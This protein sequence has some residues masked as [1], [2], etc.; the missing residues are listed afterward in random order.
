MRQRAGEGGS[1]SA[2]P[3]AEREAYFAH[4]YTTYK[5]TVRAGARSK[6]LADA[7]TEDVAQEVFAQVWRRMG[8]GN[9]PPASA[10]FFWRCG[11]NRALNRLSKETKLYPLSE[12]WEP[13]GGARARVE[14]QSLSQPLEAAVRSL[15]EPERTVLRACEVA[16]WPPTVACGLLNMKTRTFER[17]RSEARRR[18]ARKLGEDALAEPEGIAG[19]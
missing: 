12:E 1:A 17:R 7:E 18:L 15:S 13:G 8:A 6:G 4:L 14:R 9:P 2:G 5:E 19:A 10:A 11:C 3:F 16:G